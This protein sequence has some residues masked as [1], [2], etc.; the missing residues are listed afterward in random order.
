MAA[1]KTGARIGIVLLAATVGLEA[2]P[3]AKA[4]RT[5]SCVFVGDIM[6]ARRLEPLLRA[7][8]ADAC[9]ADVAP[10]LHRADIAFGNLESALSCGD[11]P[12]PQKLYNFAAA[13]HHA[14]AL[15]TAGFDVLSLANN[16]VLD[17]GP[18]AIARTKALLSGLGI[19]CPGA[20]NCEV[21]AR[22]PAYVD[23]QGVMVAFLCYCSVLYRGIYDITIEATRERPGV[24]RPTVTKLKDDIAAVRK[25]ADIVVV[26][27][28]SGMEY[29]QYPSAL[30]R[31]WAHTAIDAGADVVVMHHPHVLQGFELYR[32]G[33][34]AYSLGD[35]VFDKSD[36]STLPS[37]ILRVTF[38]VEDGHTELAGAQVIPLFISGYLPRI[39]GDTTRAWILSHLD[40]LSAPFGTRVLD[41]GTCGR[42]VFANSTAP[43]LA[44]EAVRLLRD[45]RAEHVR[46]VPQAKGVRQTAAL[47]VPAD[48]RV[49]RSVAVELPD[50]TDRMPGKLKL[51]L[52]TGR[53]LLL[54]SDFE[55]QKP[56][57][58]DT[59]AGWKMFDRSRAHSGSQSLRL[60]R[61]VGDARR[62]VGM[63]RLHDY[64]DLPRGQV[65]G[66][67]GS[68]TP[69][70]KGREYLARGFVSGEDLRS[71]GLEVR[72][73]E[74][75]YV[76]EFHPVVRVDRIGCSRAG[77]P[78]EWSLCESQL[79]RPPGAS[80]ATVWCSYRGVPFARHWRVA[81]LITA[82]WLAL[83]VLVWFQIDHRY[84][85]LAKLWP[86]K[87]A[88]RL[89]GPPSRQS[90]FLQSAGILSCVA[91]AAFF[92]SARSYVWF[93][94]VELI[95]WGPWRTIAPATRA[96]TERR[97]ARELRFS[98]A[99]SASRA[100]YVQLRI[101]RLRHS[102]QRDLTPVAL[103]DTLSLIW[104]G[105]PSSRSASALSADR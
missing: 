62:A 103:P 73:Y 64:G 81:A 30:Q 17:F 48:I 83:L 68:R 105:E 20:G 23:A 84:D 80:Y 32:R 79:T 57:L 98:P 85:R 45:C 95:E 76:N 14:P 101:R 3:P 63:Q 58:W 38:R 10:L 34:I 94:D 70:G 78:G 6:L 47:P 44:S 97:A 42:V 72:W 71:A 104:E 1:A 91:L 7:R 2:T 102:T 59:Q 92:G 36:Y 15:R 56:S 12:H 49:L 28:H 60:E 24:A 19:K 65:V 66:R 93:D 31:K 29:A 74:R 77:G 37:A 43:R 27:I 21:E 22:R 75:W 100:D 51:Q 52:R 96:S 9:F 41:D 4:D 90:M 55:A 13:P 35:F 86:G 25:R 54:F 33:L 40:L 39:P 87:R 89:R 16:H 82:T 99:E 18:E 46:L 53:N 67:Q 11:A 26:S 88:L 69:L 8:G 5:V 50:G 61:H